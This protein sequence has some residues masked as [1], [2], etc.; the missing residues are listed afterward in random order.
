MTRWQYAWLT[1]QPMAT[2]GFSHVQ[3]S[4]AA[5]LAAVLGPAVL[6]AQSTEWSVTFDRSANLGYLSGLLGDRGWE[7]IAVVTRLQPG[8]MA[9]TQM[10]TNWYFKRPGEGAAISPMAP[11][12]APAPAPTA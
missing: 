1:D 5:E 12:P 8:A 11:A 2:L 4:L 6:V 10:Q 9:P 7:M 3:P